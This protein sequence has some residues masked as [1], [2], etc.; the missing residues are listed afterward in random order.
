MEGYLTAGVI[1]EK[2][3]TI[4]EKAE[5]LLW[6]EQDYFLFCNHMLEKRE[7]K[8]ERGGGSDFQKSEIEFSFP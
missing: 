8:A 7:R 1:E 5:K 4:Y 6:R 3:S 2:E